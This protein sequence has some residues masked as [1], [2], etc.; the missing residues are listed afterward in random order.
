MRGTDG[1]SG[2][3]THHERVRFEGA[4]QGLLAVTPTHIW[5]RRVIDG[6]RE[7]VAD[8][9]SSV[10]DRNETFRTFRLCPQLKIRHGAW[11][12]FRAFRCSRAEAPETT[13]AR[14]WGRMSSMS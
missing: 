10:C 5:R 8:A 14:C 13:R 6:K 4:L 11:H 7:R 1:R 2:G 12:L 9:E 3:G